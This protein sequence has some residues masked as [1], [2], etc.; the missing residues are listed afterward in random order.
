MFYNNPSQPWKYL[1]VWPYFRCSPTC[2]ALRDVPSCSLLT[3]MLSDLRRA[4]SVM[5]P[6]L[7]MCLTLIG[8]LSGGPPSGCGA[9]A[10]T[11]V[12]VLPACL[13]VSVSCCCT[14]WLKIWFHFSVFINFMWL[15][16]ISR[17]P[18]SRIWPCLTLTL[19]IELELWLVDMLC[20]NSQERKEACSP[21]SK[22]TAETGWAR[23]G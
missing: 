17:R 12:R 8:C 10:W 14:C 16:C 15:D 9:S 21:Q 20:K 2:V 4:P 6:S 1:N 13:H 23:W 19:R 3:E 5:L 18:A 7:N 11:P 22:H